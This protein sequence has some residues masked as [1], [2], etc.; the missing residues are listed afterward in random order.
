[1]PGDRR[2]GPRG[3][4]R[5]EE[6]LQARAAAEAVMDEAARKDATLAAAEP[7]LPQYFMKDDESSRD[8]DVFVPTPEP[9]F[10]VRRAHD[11]E[12]VGSSLPGPTEVD[13]SIPPQITAAQVTQPDQLTSLIQTLAAQTQAT[14][15][16]QQQMQS[17]FQ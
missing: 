6:I 3:L 10:R 8:D 2:R 7:S 15:Q 13:S 16:V 17:Q 5:A 12:V 9:V 11:D 14:L 4:W 1:M